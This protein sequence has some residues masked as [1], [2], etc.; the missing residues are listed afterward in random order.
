[1]M[2]MSKA[3][4]VSEESWSESES[5][6]GVAQWAGAVRSRSVTNVTGK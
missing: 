5:K 1:M 3:I 4:W 6:A 2:N